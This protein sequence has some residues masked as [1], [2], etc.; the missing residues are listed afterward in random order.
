LVKRKVSK[1]KIKKE[2]SPTKVKKVLEKKGYKEGKI[3]KGKELHHTKP[4]AKGGK[5]TPKNTRVI[6]K[7]KHKNIH[8]NRRKRGKI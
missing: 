6:S 8:K 4:V 7:A 2:R 3:P 1:T 5:T